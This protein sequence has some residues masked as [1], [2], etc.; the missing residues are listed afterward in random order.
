[1]TRS[2]ARAFGTVAGG[3]VLLLAVPGCSAPEDV[4][5]AGFPEPT[6]R[7]T[8]GVAD[9]PGRYSWTVAEDFARRVDGATSGAVHV[10]VTRVGGEAR[11]W[12][13]E[14]A[15]AAQDGEVDL[16]LVQ[17][18]AWDA[19]EVR[20]L[21]ALYVPFLVVDEEHLDAVAT[22]E[23]AD[24]LLAG[25]E[26]TGVT[27][28][29]I[30]PGG[31]RHLFSR[32]TAV[33]RPDDLRGQ[34]VRSGYSATV[35]AIFHELGAEPDDPNGTELDSMLLDGTIDA[36]DSMFDLVDEALRAPSTA[37]DVALYPLALT[38]VAD[39]DRFDRLPARHREALRLSAGGTTA[40]AAQDRRPDA[41]EARLFCER[42]PGGQVVLAGDEAVRQWRDATAALAAR[43]RSDPQVGPL[44]D[45]IEQ[46]GT[47]AARAQ[48]VRPCRADPG[49]GR[50]PG[51]AAPPN[52][53]E[54]FPEGVYGKEI[55]VEELVAAGVHAADAH[56][57]AGTWRITFEDGEFGDAGCPGST[58]EVVDARVVVTLGPEGPS[59]GTA[60][61]KVLFSAGWQLVGTSLTLTDVRSGHGSDLLIAGIFG[62]APWTKLR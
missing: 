2:P 50:R 28:L 24:D 35:W 42:V 14:L 34:V 43:L 22:S 33:L 27:G 17:A 5:L 25:L 51:T 1:M 44:A 57:H 3:V 36:V 7:L 59:C 16:A 54:D 53:P 61:G 30:V 40:W 49:D 20:S 39:D 46:V 38:L 31:M 4:S 52:V 8:L 10:E 56:N 32:D 9:G 13:Q 15:R 45:R 6:V 47:G 18:Q 58:Y 23:V 60:A 26:D 29:S 19:L 55:T 48:P 62:T 37:G 11:G 12:N 41:E 21:S